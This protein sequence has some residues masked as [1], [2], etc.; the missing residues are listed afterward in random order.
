M[1]H[2]AREPYVGVDL[3]RLTPRLDTLALRAGY[4]M[5]IERH[6]GTGEKHYPNGPIAEF[7]FGWKYIGLNNTFRWGG[8][9]EPFYP[10]CGSPLYQG[11]PF[12]QSDS[13]YN[14]TD[15]IFYFFR[16]RFV[17]CSAQLNFHILPESF[18]FQQQLTVRFNLNDKIW[19][20]KAGNK[21]KPY[22]KNIY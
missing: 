2:I 3:T 4:Y 1:D 17:N 21:K 7:R 22:L 14:R 11:D 10:S 6:R 12:Y 8:N 5:G 20:E 18:N 19:K 9:M 16:N 13:W 15:I